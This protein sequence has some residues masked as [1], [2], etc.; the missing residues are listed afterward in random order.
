VIRRLNNPTKDEFE[1]ILAQ[2]FCDSPHAITYKLFMAIT[3]LE[4]VEFP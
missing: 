1:A 3:I 4:K 2:H